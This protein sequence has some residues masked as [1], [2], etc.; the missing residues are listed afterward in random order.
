MVS[1]AQL[2]CLAF[3]YGSHFLNKISQDWPLT[4]TTQ[5]STSKLSDNPGLAN[6]GFE[7][8]VVKMT[9]GLIYAKS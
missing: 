1:I 5:L 6:D 8:H 3:L 9:L 7:L 2:L 4:L